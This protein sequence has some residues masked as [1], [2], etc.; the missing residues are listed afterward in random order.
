MDESAEQ[1]LQRIKDQN[2]ARAKKYYEAHKEVISQRRKENR[3][4]VNKIVEEA[5]PKLP[6]A[7]AKK[8]ELRLQT[9]A[10]V[11]KSLEELESNKK[12][13]TNINN[14]KQLI[15]ILDITDITKAFI[16]ST[17]VI[18]K[19]ENATLQRDKTKKYS[20]NSKKSMYQTIL[21]LL[22]NFDI[23]VPDKSRKAYK[24]KHDVC[25]VQSYMDS[26]EAN[27]EEVM[28]WDEYLQL[29]VDKF[30]KE[31]KQYIIASLYKL[32]GFRDN[33]Q[34]KIVSED[35]KDDKINY[36]I[37]PADHNNI[38]NKRKNCTVI[39]NTYKTGKLY[40]SDTIKLTKEL[41][42]LIRKYMENN[43]ISFGQY[44][45]GV[46][47][48]SGYIS[49]FNATLGL[50]IAIN[51]LRHMRVSN[52]FAERDMTA[53]ERV[54]LGEEMKHAPPTSLRYKNPVK[55]KNSE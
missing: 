14:T 1:K 17:K 7:E 46:S 53:K 55:G 39:L 51:K 40:N 2:K 45:F 50:H 22:D 49:K 19:I 41:S 16:N 24:E 26:E 5:Q 43:N 34:L 44:L 27:K 15:N 10:D 36:I 48:L 18:K 20:L 29:V 21:Y 6:P 35:P 31:S 33:L 4:K 12:D 3:I 8:K 37:V 9:V 28:S 11:I 38:I 30:G 32:S 23:T 42:D 54:I 52:R 47:K 25:K 13:K